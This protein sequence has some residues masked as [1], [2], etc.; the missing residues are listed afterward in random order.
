MAWIK[1]NLFFVI[2]AVVGLG[3]T[4]YCG[5]LLFSAVHNNRSVSEEYAGVVANLKNAQKPPLP[6]KENIEAA[7]ADQERVKAFL[8]EFH[9]AFAPLPVPPK[10]DEQ[11]FKDYLQATIYKWG[12]E[13]TNAGVLLQD[14]Y[15]FSFSSIKDKLTFPPEDIPL[16]MQQIEEIKVILNILYKSK[17]LYLEGVQRCP[18]APEDYQGNDCIYTAPVTNATGVSTPY[19]VMFRGFSTEIAA[20]L[21]GFASA[22]NCFIVKDIDVAPSRAPL[23]VIVPPPANA[24]PPPQQNPGPRYQGRGRGRGEGGGDDYSYRRP[25]YRQQ[26]SAPEVAEPKGPQTIITEGVLFVT[27]SVD[28][29]RLK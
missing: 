8:A 23:P 26:Q 11:G 5:Y 16:W 3:V 18:V 14:S 4:G 7:K 1:R 19:K 6:T 22:S 25:Q 12:A 17:I 2:F 21:S 9:K 24:P 10:E 28:L 29:V 20:V 27:V 15:A 13:A